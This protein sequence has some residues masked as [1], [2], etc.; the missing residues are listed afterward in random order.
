LDAYVIDLVQ[1]AR[2]GGPVDVRR[3]PRGRFELYRVCEVEL[4][5]A[6]YEPRW[7]RSEHVGPLAGNGA[8]R[9]RS[10]RRA[11]PG[12]AGGSDG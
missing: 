8:V 12:S 6:A 11:S 1:I 2:L 7:R 4:R 3:F 10:P 5:R 9:G